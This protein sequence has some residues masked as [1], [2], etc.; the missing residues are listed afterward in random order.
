MLQEVRLSDKRQRRTN[1]ISPTPEKRNTKELVKFGA[2]ILFCAI[3]ALLFYLPDVIT[4]VS[5]SNESYVSDEEYLDYPFWLS[6]SEGLLWLL[7]IS[8]GIAFW[9]K[10]NS[11]LV[12]FCYFTI[13][14][15]LFF[16]FYTRKHLF[17]APFE[18][19]QIVAYLGASLLH[20]LIPILF[21]IR[22]IRCVRSNNEPSV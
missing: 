21:M 20:L 7:L 10:P 18:T 5:Q 14:F 12:M 9:N 3:M 1:G 13:G 11:M 17:A 19:F 4:Y 15:H 8:F 6:A 2:M 22:Q 16:I